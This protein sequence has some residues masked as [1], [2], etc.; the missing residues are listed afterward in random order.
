M[1][2]L[3]QKLLA[4]VLGLS[5][6]CLSG[7]EAQEQGSTLTADILKIGKADCTLFQEGE[8]SY[9]IDTGEAENAPR[10]LEALKEKNVD[11]LDALIISHFDKDHV[12]GAAQILEAVTV[13]RVIEPDYTPENP[14]AEAYVSYRQA[15]EKS[16]VA[17]TKVSDKLELT[18]GTASL[19]VLGTGGRAY[20]KN[21]D[22]NASL[23][24][25]ITH[26]GNRLLFAGDVEKQR[27][28]DLLSAGVTSCDF[29]KVPHHGRYNSALPEYFQALGMKTAAITCSNKNPADAETL[30]ALESLGCKVYETVNGD[31]RVSSSAS[32]IRVSQK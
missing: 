27:I 14:E 11:H 22:N 32:G 17:V 2:F 7:C 13:D 21:G 28:Q 26:E 23:L 20:A 4:L 8:T 3:Y 18:L 19:T 25:Y 1:R 9:M 12:G 24:V 16:G 15:L 29:L 30:A 31:V 5:I 10:I 6:V